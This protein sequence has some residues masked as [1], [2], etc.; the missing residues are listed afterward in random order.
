MQAHFEAVKR[1][2]FHI[3]YRSE[4]HIIG[5]DTANTRNRHGRIWV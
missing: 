5:D 2:L 3:K 1:V 4:R